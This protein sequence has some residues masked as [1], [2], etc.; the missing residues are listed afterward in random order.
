[1]PPPTVPGIQDKNSNPLKLFSKA[2]FDKVLS[3]TALPA[4]IISSFNN[5]ILL[6]FLLN[7]ITTP[8][9][10]LSEINVFEPAPSIK[11]FSLFFNF[12]K[13]FINSLRLFAE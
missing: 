5:E 12:F 7:L 9:Y 8:L 1:M 13:N 2:K 11:I 6:K 3:K 4:I 10:K